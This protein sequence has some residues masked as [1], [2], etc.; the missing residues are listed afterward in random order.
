LLRPF[1]LVLRLVVAMIVVGG[2][3]Y[4]CRLRIVTAALPLIRAT[5]V[6]VDADF[7]VLSLDVARDAAG[8]TLRL[9][10]NLAHPVLVA[11]GT[12]YPIGWV[13]NAAG[14]GAGGVEVRLTV[15]GVLSHAVLLLIIAAAWPVESLREGLVRSVT[16]L[17]LATMLLMMN[18]TSTFHA[19]L[20]NQ[21]ARAG[22]VSA[23]SFA[24][25]WS[26][27]LMGGGGFATALALAAIAAAMSRASPRHIAAV[28]A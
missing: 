4:S 17:L 27:F 3:A 7:R 14:A 8:E 12:L 23:A 19:E 21:V 22:D 26:R 6:R 10:A 20:W 13:S 16:S 18:V 11:G 9:R 28:P 5:L 24:L 15:G 2:L 25:A 1:E